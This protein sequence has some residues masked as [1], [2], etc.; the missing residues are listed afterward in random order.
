MPRVVTASSRKSS[1]GLPRVRTRTDE[2]LDR[3]RVEVPLI[4]LEVDKSGGNPQRWSF[5]SFLSSR[6]SRSL[7]V[8]GIPPGGKDGLLAV[9]TGV[10]RR[11]NKVVILGHS[12]SFLVQERVRRL[13]WCTLPTLP[14]VYCPVHHPGT[15]PPWVHH[16][17]PVLFPAVHAVSGGYRSEGWILRH[18]WAQ[19]LILAWVRR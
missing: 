17:G 3:A 16:P 9:C 15:P 6:F 11:V 14:C 10:A 12:W 1:P 7:P 19:R 13:P 5:W 18:L 4:N 2:R 8:R